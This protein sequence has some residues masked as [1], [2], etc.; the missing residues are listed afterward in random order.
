MHIILKDGNP[1]IYPIHKIREDFPN[2]SFPSILS[3]ELLAKYNIFPVVPTTCPSYD[4]ETQKPVQADTP[5]LVDGK[6]IR[7]WS[8]VDKT[9][10]ELAQFYANKAV[11]IRSARDI[12]L[13]QSDWVTV[14]AVEEN[15]KDGLGIQIPMVWLDYRQALRD[16]P[17]QDGF[18][19]TVNW[20]TSP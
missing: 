14:K 18:P 4:E 10:E 1:E 12:L 15:A 2:V 16:L 11:E 13:A 17:L 19:Q 9:A 20:P 8:I 5:T 3:E 6:W 7:A